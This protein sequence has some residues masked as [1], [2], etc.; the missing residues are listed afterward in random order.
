MIIPV[1]ANA[2][3]DSTPRRSIGWYVHLPF[4]RTKCG[5]CDFYSLPTLPTLIDGLI[6]ALSH[7]L[8]EKDPARPVETVFIG[9]GTPTELPAEALKPLLELIR[10]RAGNVR[11]Y[12]VEA[13]PS[14][15]DELKLDLLLRSGANRISFGA[16]SFDRRDLAILERLHDPDRIA[17]SVHAARATGFDN[18]NLDLIYAVP[19]QTLGR[20]RDTLRRA[21]DLGTEHLSCY[22]LMYEPGTSLTRLRS[23]GRIT[24]CDEDLECEMFELT[25]DELT[26]AG[27]EHYEISNFARPGRQCRA[28]LIYWENREYLGIGPSAVSFLDGVRRKNVADVRKYVELLP[29][30]PAAVVVEQERLSPLAHACETAV[31]SLRLTRG[32]DVESFQHRTGFGAHILFEEPIRRF[33]ALGL[34]EADGSAIRLTRRGLLV[35]NRVMGEF[36]LDDSGTESRPAPS[37]RIAAP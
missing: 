28:N 13:N 9:G 15:T 35:A 5:Y 14:S 31:Q 27:F 37:L 11:E 22:A 30:D 25:I 17:E 24:P 4:C 33:S 1:H 16:Q 7:E 2:P 32:I 12:S 26:A 21:I 20:W 6:R 19:G 10:D 23:Q 34:I 18:L 36:L 29:S 8:R 3:D